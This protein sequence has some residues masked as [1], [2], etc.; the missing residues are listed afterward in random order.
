MKKNKKQVNANAIY[1]VPGDPIGP[2]IALVEEIESF[3]LAK[4]KDRMK[5]QKQQVDNKVNI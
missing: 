3:K 5:P 1:K 2:K 4:S